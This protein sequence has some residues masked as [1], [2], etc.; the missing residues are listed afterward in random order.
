MGFWWEVG[1]ISLWTWGGVDI[2][3]ESGELTKDGTGSVH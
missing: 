3:L 2:A 1:S